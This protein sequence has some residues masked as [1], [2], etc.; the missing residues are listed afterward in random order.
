MID[1]ELYEEV[2]TEFSQDFEFT[3]FITTV[4][5]GREVRTP[6]TPTSINCYIHPA[7][8]EDIKAIA[9]DGY[10]LED[11]VKIFAPVDADILTD[12]YVSYRSQNYR[13][14]KTNIK[15][16]GDYSKFFAELVKD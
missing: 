12:D 2:I 16:V 8:N 6:Q 7:S 9:Q 1:F 5:T 3:R 10:H 11:M 4:V 14:M 13:V 15:V